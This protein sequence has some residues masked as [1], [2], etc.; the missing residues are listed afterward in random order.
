MTKKI[1]EF[2]AY[3]I[4]D[5]ILLVC[6]YVSENFFKLRWEPIVRVTSCGLVVTPGVPKFILWE[7]KNLLRRVLSLYYPIGLPLKVILSFNLTR[8]C[9]SGVCTII[10]PIRIAYIL[11]FFFFFLE[12]WCS[13][14]CF[15]F[16]SFYR[17]Y[18]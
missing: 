12:V 14:I 11:S 1:D 5:I 18:Y 10:W 16:V 13:F 2:E 9:L 15:F 3:P 4:D 6:C 17:Y 8:Q 7:I